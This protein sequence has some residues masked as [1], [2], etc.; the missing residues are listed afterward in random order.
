MDLKVRLALIKYNLLRF[1]DVGSDNYPN[2]IKAW[3]D[4]RFLVCEYLQLDGHTKLVR[5]AL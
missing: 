2:I 1:Y 4:G 3:I 5:Y